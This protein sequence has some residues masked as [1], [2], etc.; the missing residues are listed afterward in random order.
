[1]FESVLSRIFYLKIMT[2][3]SSK[4]GK[5]CA[6]N[7]NVPFTHSMAGLQKTYPVTGEH[8]C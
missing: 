4:L 6:G 5:C 8:C 2:V 1:M 3:L 7:I